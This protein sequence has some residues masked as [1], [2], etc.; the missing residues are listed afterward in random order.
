MIDY[1]SIGARHP[2]LTLLLLILV[3]LAAGVKLDELQLHL[4]ARQMMLDDDAERDFYQLCRDTFGA[5]EGLLLLL[6][7]RELLTPDKIAAIRQALQ[8]VE[9]LPQVAGTQSLFSLDRVSV[10]RSGQVHAE[11]YLSRPPA[12][13]GETADWL[14]DALRHPLTRDYLL[15]ADGRTMGVSI[16]LRENVA[17][18]DADRELVN[19]VDAILA[20]LARQLEL[21]FQIGPAPLRQAIGDKILAELQTLLPASLG[22]LMLI[23]ALALRRWEGALIPTATAVM[24]VI[25]TLGLMAYLQLPL[26][27]L[28]AI[29]PALLVVVGSTEDVH[30]LSEYYA[31]RADGGSHRHALRRMTR[32]M[33]LAV[34]LT[35]VT[36]TLGFLSIAANPVPILR[37]FA[38]VASVGLA[39]NFIVT[40]LTIPA[41]LQLAG[42]RMAGGPVP[43]AVP[44]FRGMADRLMQT[45]LR[46]P[47]ALRI[48]LALSIA[49]LTAGAM[50]IQVDHAPLGYFQQDE[51]V[52]RRVQ[53]LQR[54]LTGG[55]GFS[56]LLD[57]RIEGTFARVRYLEEIARLQ[58][59]L[60]ASGQFR[61]TL[62]FAD[63]VAMVNAVMDGPPGAAPYLPEYDDL[64][65]EYLLFLER[66]SIAGFVSGD[67]SLTRILVRH[68]ID[69]SRELSLTL[70]RLQAELDARLPKGIEAHIVGEEVMTNRAAD[71]IALGQAWS[72]ALVLLAIWALIS[73]VFVDMRAGLIA[74]SPHLIPI[75]LLFGVM[76]WAGIPLDSG[77]VMVAAI[78]L[79]VCVDDTTHF[80][81]RY[82][83]ISHHL[84]EPAEALAATVKEEATPLFSTSLALAAGFALLGLS[85]FPPIALFGLLSAMVV[86]AALLA[87][88]SI[89]PLLLAPGRLVSLW[90]L[91]DLPLRRRVQRDCLLF[92]GMKTWQI[93]KLILLSEVRE[94][95][96]GDTLFQAGQPGS[97]LHVVLDGELELW[98][99][100]DGPFR[101]LKRCGPGESVG[102]SAL[103][104]GAPYRHSATALAPTR[105]LVLHWEGIR[106][107]VRRHPRIA[108]DLFRNLSLILGGRDG[109]TARR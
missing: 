105:T 82:H 49:V 104:E 41:W 15:S 60:E 29:V 13:P 61:K 58:Q 96:A 14:R 23:L 16:R 102:E 65:Q 99:G 43:G 20:P 55:H 87:T 64:V 4:S 37:E 71:T 59:D 5:G 26:N 108:A 52:V 68:D 27:V 32:R 57:A 11:P 83:Q 53:D 66:E 10:D 94:L 109:A 98:G 92:R 7:D 46:R 69:S 50:R 103:L 73:L 67:F 19:A 28:T 18:A 76:G 35:F 81:L 2:R 38:L 70:E 1:L 34:L 31:G 40:G 30:L 17:S 6:H 88:F 56:I 24:S 62:S 21:A 63:I 95:A 48:L 85:D 100:E 22:L 9:Q 25:W 91:L 54:L 101:A 107:V 86:L 12:T 45:A 74:V 84:P 39:F 75:A 47:A 3:T 33:G 79:G 106:R 77:T 51:E 89:T 80:M 44:L 97:A 36:T 93:K 42:H 90:D 72:L 78:A 8:A